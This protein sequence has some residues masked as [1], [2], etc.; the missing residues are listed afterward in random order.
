MIQG[1][2]LPFETFLK[3]LHN[4]KA[5]NIAHF[6][7]NIEPENVTRLPSTLKVAKE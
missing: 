5:Q 2:L 6:P 7:Y 4:Y 3:A 1:Y